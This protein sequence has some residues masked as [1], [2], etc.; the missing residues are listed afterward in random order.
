MNPL[1][2]NLLPPGADYAAVMPLLWAFAAAVL[3][4][5]AEMFWPYRSRRGVGWLTIAALLAI[6]VLGRAPSE[7]VYFGP[8]ALD[9]FSGW[10]NGL[11]CL[12]AALSVLMSLDTLE[13]NGVTRGEYYPL[14]LF[15]VAG[16]MVMAAATD[17]VVMFL[18]LE[19]MSMAVYVLAGM[20]KARRRSNEASLKYFLLGAFASAFMLYGIALLYSQAGSTDLAA[21]AGLAGEG[22]T[23]AVTRL[24]AAL[25][26]VGFGF[27]IAAVP[28]H[29]W[30]PDVYE[31]APSPVTAFMATVVKAAAFA[32]LLRS[33]LLAMPWVAGELQTPLWVAAA[34]TMTVGNL[35]ALRQRSLKRMLA[36]SSVAHT[37]YLAMAVVAGTSEAAAALLFYLAAY[38]AMNLGAFAVM[39]LLA[40]R[41]RPAENI[42]DLAGLGRARPLAALAMTVC[43]LS[44]TGIP[45]LGGFVAKVSLFGAVL[46]AGF[47][48]LV[49]VAVL[50]SVLS[51]AYYLGVIRAMYFDD[52]DSVAAGGASAA[53]R[54]LPSRPALTV[55]ILLAALAVVLIGLSPSP[56]LG[57]SLRALASVAGF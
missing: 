18:G 32:A 55:S 1:P 16:G 33:V 17:L 57:S 38:A 56:L 30:A 12:V 47:Y 45:P 24:G 13:V 40:D 48:T 35:A 21:M 9:G 22:G 46:D 6:A 11:L 54:V 27:K 3:V 28:F 41:G 5:I 8:I 2:L 42:S 37:G 39:M 23:S 29:L 19:T 34:A 51:A 4:L 49:V 50:N 14:L 10:C 44:L 15:A 43:M 20:G 52:A 31:G 25:L 36:F 26:L 53:S 7:A